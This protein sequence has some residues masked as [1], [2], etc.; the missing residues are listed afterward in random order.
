MNTTTK[1]L[2]FAVI[3]YAFLLV[4][5]CLVKYIDLSV[6]ISIYL[7]IFI[8]SVLFIILKQYYAGYIFLVSAGIGL[9]LEYIVS[10]SHVGRPNMSGAFLNTVVLLFGGVIGIT[11]QIVITKKK[12]KNFKNKKDRKR[13]VVKS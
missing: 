9:L 5:M 1:Q 11:T 8:I 4:T 12:V 10:L 3:S 6:V 13:L 7:P 2:I